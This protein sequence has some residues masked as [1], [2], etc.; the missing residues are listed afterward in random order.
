[1][2]ELAVKLAVKLAVPLKLPIEDGVYH[3]EQQQQ[4][5][6]SAG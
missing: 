4:P 2:G 5:N 6:E 3:S 1:M